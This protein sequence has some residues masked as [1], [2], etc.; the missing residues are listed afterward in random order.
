MIKITS[1]E[2][3]EIYLAPSAIAQITEA[4]SASQWHGIRSYIK[5][6]DGETIECRDTVSEVVAALKGMYV[7]NQ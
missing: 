1:T 7:L 2:G 5:T 6:F 4:A 3:R